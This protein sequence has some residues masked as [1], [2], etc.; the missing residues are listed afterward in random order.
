PNTVDDLKHIMVM[1]GQKETV[2]KSYT[3][4]HR[5]GYSLFSPGIT[6]S[7]TDSEAK[8]FNLTLNDIL[9]HLKKPGS[10]VLQIDHHERYGSPTLVNMAWPLTKDDYERLRKWLWPAPAEPP[11]TLPPPAS[12]PPPAPELPKPPPE[13]SDLLK[14]CEEAVREPPKK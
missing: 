6:Q 5:P 3:R 12:E 7:F 1:S 10:F 11:A 4:T 8:D 9:N 14:K 2:R 13:K